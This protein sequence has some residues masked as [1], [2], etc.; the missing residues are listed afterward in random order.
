MTT[1]AAITLSYAHDADPNE[2]AT[3][4]QLLALLARYDLSR[5]R[6]TDAV[7]VERRAIPHS[8]PILTL[9]TRHLDDDG[10]LL[11]T[12]LHEQLHWFLERHAEDALRA[13]EELRARYPQPPVGF[14]DGAEDEFSSHA[15]YIVCYLEWRALVDVVGET[16]ATRIFAFWRGDHYRAIYAAVMDDGA[17]I[18]EI[19]IRCVGLP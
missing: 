14:P 3:G 2:R 8:H 15:H 17:A 1:P 5:W 7:R 9:N 18:G 19:V 11:A 16:E 10:L 12:Y 4:V 13:I 6:F